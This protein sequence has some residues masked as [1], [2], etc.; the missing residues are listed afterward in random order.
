MIY[1]P[2]KDKDFLIIKDIHDMKY[3]DVGLLK[4][5]PLW[6]KQVRTDLARH[7]GFREFAYPD[8]RSKL[9]K[10]K[11][12]WGFEPAEIILA[13]LGLSEKDGRPWTVGYGFTRNV[14]PTH[15]I[16]RQAA[17]NMLRDEI[18]RH[19]YIVDRAVPNWKQ[20]PLF[21]QTVLVNL[22]YNLGER[23]F[24]FEP[25]MKLFREG[26]FKEAAAR[27][28]R[29]A[30]YRQVGSRSKELVERLE[31]EDIQERYKVS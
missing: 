29:T 14:R 11:A 27:L 18:I 17:D 10:V 5:E 4:A 19:L 30:W 9:A 16:N 12:K 13:R 23:L 1:L 8:P 21:A 3:S 25:T 31:I 26:K 22:A 28:R 6:L 20:L 2:L 15:R 7:E 24:Q